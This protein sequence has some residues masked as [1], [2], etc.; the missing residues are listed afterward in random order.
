MKKKDFKKLNM[1][2]TSEAMPDDVYEIIIEDDADDYYAKKPETDHTDDGKKE[3]KR[4]INKLSLSL[5]IQL[6]AAVLFTV[7]VMIIIPTTAWFSHENEIAVSTK[8]N[9]PATL[10]IKAGGPAGAEQDIVNFELSDIDTE[11]TSY[12]WFEDDNNVKHYYK[13]FVFCVKGKAISSY[14]LQLA[15][16]TNIAFT[17]DVYRAIQDNA[18]DIEYVS[19][20]KTVTQNYKTV[21]VS[22]NGANPVIED[23]H[24][25]YVDSNTPLGG[26]YINNANVSNSG[27]IIAQEGGSTVNAKD[28]T[29]RSYDGGENHQIY[30]NPVYWVTRGIQVYTEEKG[31]DG[32]THSYVLRISWVMK[33]DEDDEN[34]LAVVQN[35]KETDIIYITAAVGSN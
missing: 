28:L 33:D 26:R 15:H 13:D 19:K 7:A 16:T 32:F 3:K 25:V 5:R 24:I 8:I 20:D 1:I 21:E 4:G 18:G 14:D 9:S 2:D 22:M 17:Y 27:R 12:K 23:G 31:D 30:A 35:N 6:I 29:G 34:D 11:D 10:E